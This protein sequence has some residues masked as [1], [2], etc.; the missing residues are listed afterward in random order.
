[1]PGAAEMKVLQISDNL[2]SVK[3]EIKMI[4][5]CPLSNLYFH[6]LSLHSQPFSL[7]DLLYN[8]G[9]DDAV[10]LQPPTVKA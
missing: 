10:S 7:D 6:L 8:I 4:S 3:R 1:M 2:Y 5:Y 9:H